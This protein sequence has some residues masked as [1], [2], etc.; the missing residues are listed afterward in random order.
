MTQNTN[1]PITHMFTDESNHT[2]FKQKFL[3]LEPKEGLGSVGLFSSLF[4]NPILKDNLGDIKMQFAVTPVPDQSGGEGPKLAHTAPRRQLV[5][6]LDGL[7]EFKSCDV[8]KMDEDHQT[9]ISKGQILL[10]DDLEGAGHVWSF[11]KD[12]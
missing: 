9:V 1:I 7:L 10:A 12:K 3:P 11:L 6:T 4:V 2:R 5:I 8:E